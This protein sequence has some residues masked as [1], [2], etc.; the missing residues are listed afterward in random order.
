MDGFFQAH[1]LAPFSRAGRGGEGG[2]VASKLWKGRRADTFKSRPGI[3][4]FAG[5]RAIPQ[6][7]SPTTS[8]AHSRRRGWPA[9]PGMQAR[10]LAPGGTFQ[11]R[12]RARGASLHNSATQR[13]AG[14]RGLH[15]H[16]LSLSFSA[17]LAGGVVVASQTLSRKPS[18]PERAA[19]GGLSAASRRRGRAR[20]LEKGLPRYCAQ[21][22]S[23]AP[24]H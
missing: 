18:A 11:G 3:R 7:N 8:P 1:L 22:G 14:S 13:R 16:Q 2:D 15:H 19:G 4:G 12:P 17:P 5:T 9:A 6:A 20:H 23:G 21:V 10:G 24:A